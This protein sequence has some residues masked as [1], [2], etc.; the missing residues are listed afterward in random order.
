MVLTGRG[1]H[2]IQPDRKDEPIRVG[3]LARGHRTTDAPVK[4]SPTAYDH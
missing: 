4:R 2:L 1:A 3:Q